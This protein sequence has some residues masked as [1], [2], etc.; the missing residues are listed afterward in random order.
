MYKE[1]F[2]PDFLKNL[3]EKFAGTPCSQVEELP[4][5]GSSRRYVRYYFQNFPTIIGAFNQDVKENEA[6]F[7]FTR[8]FLAR[9]IN[10]PQL[11]LIDEGKNYYLLSD[12]GDETLFS[13]LSSHRDGANLGD[14]TLHYYREVIKQLPLIQL[15][16][17]CGIDFSVCYP[18]FAF[19]RQSMQWDLNYFKYYFLKL[20]N[21][22]FDEQLLENDFNTLIE[23]LLEVDSDYFLYRDFQSRN[24]MICDDRVF[25]IDYQGG[26]RGALQ[27]D[28]ASLLYDGKADIPAQ[29]REELLNFYL[30]ELEKHIPVD[31]KDFVEHYFAFV[32]IR[33]MQAMGT[34]GFRG[35]YEKK[36]HFL[37]SIP[38]AVNNISY[39]LSKWNLPIEIPTL[40]EV[41][42]KIT[43]C[44]FV[45]QSKLS[46]DRLTV[47]VTSFSYKKGIPQDLSSNG[48]GFV[49]D[50]RA[51]PNPGRE[52]QYSRNT[53]K[54]QVIKDY[55]EKYPE[56]EEFKSHV[57]AIV[58]MSVDNYIERKFSHL[59]VNFGCTGGQHR[60]V[61]FA[62][63]LKDHLASKYD[64]SIV[65]KHTVIDSWEK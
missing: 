40:K 1:S 49:F 20:A 15:S 3:A 21:I 32:L 33:I 7:S 12:L 31:R 10:V 43:K 9:H 65:L 4:L 58:D 27:Y 37:L 2:N 19:D 29:K 23:Y 17:K 30:D 16:G 24:I 28:I 59:M 57:N 34:Y 56:V 44:D 18:R 22:P 26:R 46:T 51:L 41:L 64:I 50:C 48:G 52:K 45:Q 25:F 8:F 36:A 14:D 55:L 62:E 61:Y 47:T 13:F 38:Y 60:S 39:L 42:D 6:F 63:A 5:S 54:E 11:L 53:G 35:Y